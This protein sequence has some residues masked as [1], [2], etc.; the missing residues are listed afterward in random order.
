MPVRRR[1]AVE[2][3]N[4]IHALGPID[5]PQ[6]RSRHSTP[7]RAGGSETSEKSELTSLLT[8]TPTI[9]RRV[10]SVQSTVGSSAVHSASA[11]PPTSTPPTASRAHRI[12]TPVDAAYRPGDDEE[13]DDSDDDVSH[14]GRTMRRNRRS[15]GTADQAY[16]PQAGEEASESDD[17]TAPG[18]GWLRRRAGRAAAG[19]AARHGTPHTAAGDAI[20]PQHKPAEDAPGL[21]RRLRMRARWQSALR[22]VKDRALHAS[23]RLVA[24]SLLLVL[25]MRSALRNASGRLRT[26][27]EAGRRL[28]GLFK[29][30]G[31]I[32]ILAVAFCAAEFA[33][34]Y[35]HLTDQREYDGSAWNAAD[36]LQDIRQDHIALRARMDAFSAELAEQHAQDGAFS[37]Q[38]EHLAAEFGAE[39]RNAQK[40]SVAM[41]EHAGTLSSVL[42]DTSQH[43]K[44]LRE[45]AE[46]WDRQA[47]QVASIGELRMLSS[48]I[49]SM[50]KRLEDLR[51]KLDAY[52]ATAV[53]VATLDAA[54]AVCA[55]ALRAARACGRQRSSARTMG[56]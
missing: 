34:S 18:T 37:T 40:L 52:D 5:V 35:L 25:W 23:G 2:A 48:Q 53:S 14:G 45:M 3:A 12:H 9:V 6:H 1:A 24:L 55:P 33:K 15:Y 19:V 16:K 47:G 13:R 30:L 17:D 51:A 32:I 49:G 31:G 56:C 11:A 8:S 29:I 27:D 28:K 22:T 36:D 41:K 26:S 20:R 43:E 7:V 50:E 46:N 54:I 21:A 4:A 39:R 44:T 10:A 38:L 42:A